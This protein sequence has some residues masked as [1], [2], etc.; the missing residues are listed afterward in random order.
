MNMTIHHVS[1]QE[2]PSHTFA[3]TM[4]LYQINVYILSPS[5]ICIGT[6]ASAVLY[7]QSYNMDVY[8]CHHIY[9]L[10]WCFN[11]LNVYLLCLS[12]LREGLA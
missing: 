12:C 1:A 9:S 10:S 11:T 3:I 7:P 2:L 6:T 4:S 8:V 5:V